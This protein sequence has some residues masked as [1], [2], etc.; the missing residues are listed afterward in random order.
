MIALAT[1]FTRTHVQMPD[2][3]PHPQVPQN[4]RHCEHWH[5]NYLPLNKKEHSNSERDSCLHACWL[6]AKPRADCLGATATVVAAAA[7]AAVATAAV[8]A[9]LA[10]GC[11]GCCVRAGCCCCSCCSCLLCRLG[12]HLLVLVLVMLVF[13]QCRCVRRMT[14]AIAAA[15]AGGGG[16]VGW[17]VGASGDAGEDT[18]T[19]ATRPWT[20]TAQGR[21]ASA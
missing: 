11:E 13:L 14:C 3:V 7:A 4:H 2:W 1:E 21:L 8:H 15:A 9:L 12:L 6:C 20:G 5:Q 16:A 17:A 10:A 19:D 18:K